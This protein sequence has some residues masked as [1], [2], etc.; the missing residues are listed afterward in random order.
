MLQFIIYRFTWLNEIV[1][2]NFFYFLFADFEDKDR[3][4][5]EWSARRSWE[6]RQDSFYLWCNLVEV[7]ANKNP[8]PTIVVI[9][10]SLKCIVYVDSITHLNSYGLLDKYKWNTTVTVGCI[11]DAH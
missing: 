7:Y 11:P 4:R 2:N 5:T 8:K 6:L 10:L 9:N 1:Y 3:S